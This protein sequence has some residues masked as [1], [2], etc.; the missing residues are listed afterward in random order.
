M[1]AI[2]TSK[3]GKVHFRSLAQGINIR[4]HPVDIGF[5]LETLLNNVG[6]THKPTLKASHI[7]VLAPSFHCSLI[8]PVCSDFLFLMNHEVWLALLN[9]RCFASERVESAEFVYLSLAEQVPLG[10]G[11]RASEGLPEPQQTR[12]GWRSCQV[13]ARRMGAGADWDGTGSIRARRCG[14][15]HND[16]KRSE[17]NTPQPVVK[18]CWKEGGKSEEEGTTEKRGKSTAN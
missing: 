15:K 7:S 9:K 16:R 5:Q 10:A 17:E 1:S 18:E 11:G 3:R 14:L 2:R 12:G 13:A 6:H 8:C 4:F